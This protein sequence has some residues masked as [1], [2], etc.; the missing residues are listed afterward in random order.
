MT[1]QSGRSDP[2]VRMR[3]RMSLAKNSLHWKMVGMEPSRGGTA[4]YLIPEDVWLSSTFE[5]VF[6]KEFEAELKTACDGPSPSF[7]D[8]S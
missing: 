2:P 1:A 5:R 7:A 6:S 8:G 4:D 3:V